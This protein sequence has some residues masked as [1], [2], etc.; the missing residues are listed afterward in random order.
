MA[1]RQFCLQIESAAAFTRKF[2]FLCRKKYHII[3]GN[4][5]TA[6]AISEAKLGATN[7]FL[8]LVAPKLD[9]KISGEYQK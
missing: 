5:K 1:D 8:N 2:L 9:A 3:N 6:A 7:Y 4:C